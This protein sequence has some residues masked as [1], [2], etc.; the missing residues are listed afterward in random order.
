[1]RGGVLY[2]ILWLM[3]MPLGLLIVLWILGVG[4]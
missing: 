3:G 2:I 1:M 4:R